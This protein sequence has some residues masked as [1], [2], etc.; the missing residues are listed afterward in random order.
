MPSL[1]LEH[2]QLYPDIADIM[3]APD[4]RYV[5][6]F[7]FQVKLHT[8]HKDLDH[9]D[10]LILNSLYIYRDYVEN[11]SDYIEVQLTIPHGTYVYDVY[12]ELGNIEVTL[13]TRKQLH[14]NDKPFFR[15]ERYKAVYIL[16]KN[17]TIATT[18]NQTKEDLNQG[19]PVVITLQLLDRSAETVRVKTTQGSFGKAVNPKNKDM[20]IKSFMKSLICEECDKIL[21]E[22]KQAI[23]SV[24]IEEPDN[25][26]P[27]KGVTLSSGTR[28]VELPEYLQTKNIGVYSG[29][30]GNYIQN[31]GSDPYTYQKTFFVY[32]LYNPKKYDSSEYKI[33]MYSPASSGMSI[34]DHTY[35]Y[36]D[37][38]LKVLP[39]T[40]TK[41]HGS[42]ETNMMST[43]S[44]F[45][46]SNANSYMKKPVTMTVSGPVF[47]R[48]QLNTEVVYKDRKDNLNFAPNASVSTN[49]FA[50]SAEILS[51]RGS[52][53]PVELSNVDHD[54]IY[55]AAA[56]KISYEDPNQKV[57]EL[58]GVIH[59]AVITYNSTNVNMPLNY[60][61]AFTALTS[62]I[63]LQV[64][65]I[66]FE[67]D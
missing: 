16:E 43:G 22:N 23:D 15:T 13:T 37:K 30:I 47:E 12:N 26:E 24:Y 34:M 10:G 51:K 54:F 33:L 11:M 40:I 25:Q 32:S 67:A 1:S 19:L 49:V 59:K 5:A 56:C 46:T 61:N 42:K 6:T 60:N 14:L 7:D 8:E 45:R 41:I 29:G 31:F 2:S 17:T 38:I 55:P 20:S 48:N 52:Y 50:L 53:V 64:F 27:L 44:G 62:H 21:I 39:H 35:T 4:E 66:D 58:K 28:V 36:Q 65:I 9:T 3:R 18:V 57:K 63:T